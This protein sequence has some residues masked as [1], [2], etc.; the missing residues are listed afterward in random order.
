MI[1]EEVTFSKKRELTVAHQTESNFELTKTWLKA[2]CTPDPSRAINDFMRMLPSSEYVPVNVL[3]KIEGICFN[4]SRLSSELI[5]SVLTTLFEGS[6]CI[7]P[8]CKGKIYK[9][10]KPG[11]K[12][13]ISISVPSFKCIACA[14]SVLAT[15][16]MQ[17][18]PA[19]MI[20]ELLPRFGPNLLNDFFNTANCGVEYKPFS[21]RSKSANSSKIAKQSPLIQSV[22]ETPIM[23][24]SLTSSKIETSNPF[25]SLSIDETKEPNLNEK[26]NL[27]E[28][29]NQILKKEVEDM[30]TQL[31][32]FAKVS[33]E[34]GSVSEKKDNPEKNYASVLSKSVSID[35]LIENH[36]NLSTSESIKQLISV[37]IGL[38]EENDSMKSKIEELSIRIE[39]K[40]AK[41][42][43]G[44]YL[45]AIK[46]GIDS[47]NNSPQL[48]QGELKRLNA[49]SFNQVEVKEYATIHFQGLRS[50]AGVKSIK[51]FI[52]EIGGDI[53][54]IQLIW[55]V[56][57]DILEV[58]VYA[59]YADELTYLLQNVQKNEKY[60]EMI[61]KKIK[62]EALDQSNIRNPSCQS[63]AK[64]IFTIRMKK[65]ISFIEKMIPTIPQ[66]KRLRNY[67]ELQ[68]K[69]ESFEVHMKKN[70]HG[71]AFENI[72]FADVIAQQM[73]SFT[74]VK[75]IEQ[76]K[77]KISS[78]SE[79]V[80]DVNQ[81]KSGELN[82]DNK[83]VPEKTEEENM[84]SQGEECCQ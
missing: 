35:K 49:N 38:K 79:A 14:T 24:G 10:V 23:N 21:P 68:L 74:P 30:K 75:S 26:I 33:S 36:S 40:E 7:F 59:D 20:K 70:T 46:K 65:K 81:E 77:V 61:I 84:K 19:V 66:W 4:K 29:E 25:L 1:N 17:R 9:D 48:S 76:T 42:Q 43:Q 45:N 15:K 3:Q 53:R 55:F 63:K 13:I 62:F 82:N 51:C 16:L 47:Q 41:I 52:R 28:N 39:E 22:F 78:D 71:Q 64:D 6:S 2:E 67:I 8:S 50:S 58:T 5:E 60:K 44:P 11:R 18:V 56:S 73:D 80:G 57:R 69:L 54:K 32:A 37:C 72:S 31:S 27:L 34:N 12:P 83:T